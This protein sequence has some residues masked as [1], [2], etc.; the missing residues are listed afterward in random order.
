MAIAFDREWWQSTLGLRL[1]SEQ[2]RQFERLHTLVVDGNARMNLTRIIEREAFWEK[3]LWDS[4]RGIAVLEAGREASLIDIGSGAGFPGLPIAIYQ[5]NWYVALLDSVRKKTGFL[6]SAV[7]ALGITNVQMLTGR[8][9]DLAHRREH[10]ESYDLA[11]LRAVAPANVCAE[12]GLP[13]VGVG[14]SVVLYRGGWEV[15]EEVELAR[16][17]AA[18]GGEIAEV[19]AFS[20]PLSDAVRHAVVLR[21]LKPSMAVFPRHTGLPAQH[22]LGAIE[23]APPVCRS[24]EDEPE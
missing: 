5:P 12:Y 10:R 22:P 18:L 8:A 19:D 20:L 13:F 6:A 2:I 23:G 16:A 24:P 7:Q 17:C 9:E 1:D 21:K 15:R 3:H 14:G 4:L 11:T